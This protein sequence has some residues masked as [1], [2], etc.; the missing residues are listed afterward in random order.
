MP[1]GLNGAQQVRAACLCAPLGR[2][3]RLIPMSPH[4]VGGQG[5]RPAHAP[6]SS[7][8]AGRRRGSQKE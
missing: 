4:T 5:R 8:R 2:A 3:D 6:H 1:H 7:R